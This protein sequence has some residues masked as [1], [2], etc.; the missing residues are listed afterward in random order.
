MAFVT[1]YVRE[2]HPGE[3]YPQPDTFERKL[4]HAR[5]YRERDG[6]PWP[7]AVDDAD[8]T[9]HHALDP[10]PSS[11]YIM[12]TDGHAAFRAL[13]S[14]DERTVRKGLEAVLEAKPPRRPSGLNRVVPMTGGLAY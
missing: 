14:N 12:D 8:G 2:A 4:E 1:L 3:R 10:K 9:L 5:A 6:L 13:W 7:V 11:V